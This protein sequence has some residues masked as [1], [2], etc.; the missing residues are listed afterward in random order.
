MARPVTVNI[1][2]KLGKQE[3]RRR[4]EEGFGRLRQQMT[5]G[6]A[7]MVAFQERWEGDRLHF[8]G[9]GLGQKMTGRLDVLPDSVRVELDLPEILAAMADLITGRLQKE[10]Q[11]LLEKK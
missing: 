7:G 1:P 9:S 4:I 3:A 8:E 10:G 5:S 6:I 2:H 11:K